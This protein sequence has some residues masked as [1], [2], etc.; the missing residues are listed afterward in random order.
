MVLNNSI[1]ILS[2]V[3]FHNYEGE[4]ERESNFSF[5]RGKIYLGLSL[6]IP[7]H[8]EVFRVSEEGRYAKYKDS[9]T[10]LTLRQ[11]NIHFDQKIILVY[12]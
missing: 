2:C 1:S 10:E 7:D 11:G 9:E 3:G 12:P 6:Q 8:L 5:L 4:E